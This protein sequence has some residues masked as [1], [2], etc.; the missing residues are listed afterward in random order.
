MSILNNFKNKDSKANDLNVYYKTGELSEG[1]QITIDKFTK[2]FDK[3]QFTTSERKIFDEYKKTGELSEK[4]KEKILRKEANAGDKA[5]DE[6]GNL[7]G[8]SIDEK[9]IIPPLEEGEEMNEKG[10]DNVR[11]RGYGF[12]RWRYCFS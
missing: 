10:F 5:Y 12:K 11:G 8:V 6:N 2:R 3:G 1:A 7:I 4:L 9:N